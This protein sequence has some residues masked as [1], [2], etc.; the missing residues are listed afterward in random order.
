MA[1][2]V[3]EARRAAVSKNAKDQIEPESASVTTEA[4][5]TTCFGLAATI[6]DHRGEIFGTTGDDV[7]I[8]DDKRNIVYGEGGTDRICTGGGDDDVDTEE[9][10]GE[11]AALFADLGPGID[12][13]FS[14]S[15]GRNEVYGRGG[16]DFI[17]TDT[18]DDLVV[19]GGGGD[20]IDG[21]RGADEIHGD[22]GNDDLAGEEG[23]DTLD[24]GKGRD[25]CVLGPDSGTA[26]RCERDV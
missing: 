7:I 22:K 3:A 2:K 1:A 4:V 23:F 19:G 14:L 8:G 24:G 10:G 18:G 13:L 20:N 16:A 6:A 26:T 15:G 5:A 12:D 21:W 11:T 9:V 17:F 25:R